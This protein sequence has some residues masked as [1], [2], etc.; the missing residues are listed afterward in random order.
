MS[1]F[2][3][4]DLFKVEVENQLTLFTDSLLELERVG[5]NASNL[6]ALMRS[7]HSIKGAA[8]LVG[9]KPAE[10]LAHVL[11]DAFSAAQAG[12]IQITANEIDLFLMSADMLK[13]I[14]L[15]PEGQA[16]SFVAQNQGHY[17]D[18][19][20]RLS[21]VAA[22]QS[23]ETAKDNLTGPNQPK[24]AAPVEPASQ[25]SNKPDPPENVILEK[26]LSGAPKSI[27]GSG[28]AQVRGDSAPT[29]PKERDRSLRLTAE[30]LEALVG[31]TG[32][33]QVATGRLSTLS[34]ALVLL[35]R[36]LFDLNDILS[37]VRE[38]ISD[39]KVDF[40]NR[41]A[42]QAEIA[43]S[44]CSDYLAE[45]LDELEMYDR[46]MF[47]LASR[48]HQAVISSK[49]SA[50]SEGVVGFPR[51]VRDVARQLGK[52]VE[53][54][55]EGR[56]TSVDR[57]ILERIESPLIHLLRNSVDHGIEFPAERVRLGKP[58][59]ATIVLRAFHRAGMLSVEV[60]DD[61]RG[62]DLD[63]LRHTVV[64]RKLTSEV[65]ASSLTDEELYEFL[66]LP[67]FTTKKTVD[68]IS[69]RGV[70]LDVVRSTI[71]EI[72]G[73]LNLSSVKGQ[74]CHFSM[75]LPLTL[76]VTRN[77][78]C[79]VDREIY[80]FPLNRIQ[81][82]C[83]VLKNEIEELQGKSII[84]HRGQHVPLLTAHQ[85]LECENSVIEGDEVSVVLIE[86][87]GKT[88]G[89]AV[90]ALVGEQDMVI[91]TL[92]TRFGKLRSVAAGSIL[93]DGSPVLI[94]DV[95]DLFTSIAKL[96]EGGR[97]DNVRR[98]EQRQAQRALKR[99]LIVDDS[100]TVREVERKILELHGYEVDTAVDG[101]DGLHAVRTGSYDLVVSD[102]DMPRMDGIKLVTAIRSDN[103]LKNLPVII[104]SYKDSEKDRLRGLEAGAD[105]YLTKS[106]FD[107]D[108]F[109]RAV[110]DLIGG[111]S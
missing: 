42:R 8:R 29:G 21:K 95:E 85:L 52:D 72:G 33:V 55:I 2:S 10:R 23:E 24:A 82:V 89:V 90:D 3:L 45:Q 27:S 75:T 73:K 61:G 46:R 70:G 44:Q 104:V 66:Y 68:E 101:M 106:S 11:E 102:V 98:L 48:L 94:L 53:L 78:L 38:G 20:R 86:K 49:M 57:D 51:L 32:E 40:A 47:S 54:V 71:V 96:V 88:V 91:Q 109:V 7:G 31:L 28:N 43:A 50:F 34:G 83:Q 36:R 25:K 87:A 60:Y 65:M 64:E 103:K 74:G 13:H 67:K 12:Q 105:Y 99:V 107:D 97:L 108:S 30:R 59:K 41:T 84:R 69:G 79:V 81:G 1:D 111:S 37:K 63:Q 14:S 80:A 76:S 6:E 15:Q 77:L 26:T 18:L 92:D 19:L 35:K 9:V 56:S 5:S 16:E 58:A 39:G 100:I 22:G 93:E 17:D 62:I 110:R 4:L